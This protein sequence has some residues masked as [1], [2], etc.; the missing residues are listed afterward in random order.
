M[1]R[2][3]LNAELNADNRSTSPCCTRI[4]VLVWSTAATR[5]KR[6][7]NKRVW[8]P[9]CNLSV[10]IPALTFNC[11]DDM[12]N[13][14]VACCFESSSP[15]KQSL[16]KEH[17]SLRKDIA[18]SPPVIGCLLQD[19]WQ[20]T[21]ASLTASAPAAV[22]HNLQSQQQMSEAEDGNIKCAAN[23]VWEQKHCCTNEADADERSLVQS[24]KAVFATC[25]YQSL[26]AA[27]PPADV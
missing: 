3:L 15:T 5:C 2:Q 26:A 20:P 23:C 13:C 9:L 25:L 19:S 6:C 1:D 22:L 11:P 16:L 10:H 4:H 27:L 18:C 24:C 7:S 17:I 14:I 8:Q 21:S 12:L